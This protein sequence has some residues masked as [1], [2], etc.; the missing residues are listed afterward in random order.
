[1]NVN[2]RFEL[3]PVTLLTSNRFTRGIVLRG[4]LILSQSSMADFPRTTRLMEDCGMTVRILAEKDFPFREYYFE[5]PTFM[6][7]IE[8][9][10]NSYSL[11]DGVHYE[12]LKVFEGTLPEA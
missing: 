6:S 12:Q 10:E 9:V 5:D 11:P 2:A 4:R 7:E 1:M 3:I 8:R